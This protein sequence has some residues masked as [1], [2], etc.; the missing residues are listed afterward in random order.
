M[1][2]IRNGYQRSHM[3]TEDRVGLEGIKP[4]SWWPYRLS[5]EVSTSVLESEDFMPGVRV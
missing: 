4:Y 1:Q 5:V 3:R 2:N